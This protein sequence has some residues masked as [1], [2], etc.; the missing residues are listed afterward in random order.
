M[1]PSYYATHAIKCHQ[2]LVPP[3][4][5]PHPIFQRTP[6]DG[7]VGLQNPAYDKYV[8][9]KGDQ[10]FREHSD[11]TT[12]NA[13]LSED[14]FPDDEFFPNIDNRF[15]DMVDNTNAKTAA[16]TTPYMIMFS[17]NKSCQSF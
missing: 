1:N 17:L 10:V 13:T 8:W 4:C 12:G 7:T 6:K 5:L 9:A 15:G 2:N 3:P 14:S 16:L 11:V